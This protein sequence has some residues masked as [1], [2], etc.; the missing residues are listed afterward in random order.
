MAAFKDGG[1]SAEYLVK[2][3]RQSRSLRLDQRV[4]L[5]MTALG[6]LA[7]PKRAAT[8]ARGGWGAH[9]L[10]PASIRQIER[11]DFG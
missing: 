1:R 3:G 6:L 4:P 7:A 10:D 2:W 5:A 9:L 11:D 8:L